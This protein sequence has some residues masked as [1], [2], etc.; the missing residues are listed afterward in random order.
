MPYVRIGQ[1]KVLKRRRTLS[2]PPIL[3]SMPG[4]PSAKREQW[5]ENQMKKAIEAVRFKKKNGVN[6]AAADHGIP[7]TTLKD[8]LSGR[9][10]ENSHSG[11][12]RYLNENEENE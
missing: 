11:P 7:A 2:A 6:R 1:R 8:R 9:T 12:S 4:A 3:V 5:T 10:K